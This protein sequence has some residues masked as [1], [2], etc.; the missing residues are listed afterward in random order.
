MTTLRIRK[1]KNHDWPLHL[2]RECCCNPNV[3]RNEDNLLICQCLDMCVREGEVT[4]IVIASLFPFFS[5]S[6]GDEMSNRDYIG[7]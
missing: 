4:D 3:H 6:N 7:A 5:L 1:K 2:R